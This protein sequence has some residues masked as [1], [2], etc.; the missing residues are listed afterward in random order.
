[1]EFFFYDHSYRL[2][3]SIR[4]LITKNLNNYRIILNGREEVFFLKNIAELNFQ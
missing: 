4:H 2:R 1:M 3:I